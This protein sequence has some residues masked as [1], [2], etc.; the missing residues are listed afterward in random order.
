LLPYSF[1]LQQH[2]GLLRWLLHKVDQK[3]VPVQPQYIPVQ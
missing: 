2:I 1:S 3:D